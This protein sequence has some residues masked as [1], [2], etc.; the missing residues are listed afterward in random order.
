[1]PPLTIVTHPVHADVVAVLRQRCDVDVCERPPSPEALAA[2]A[3]GA[4]ALLAFMPDRIDARLLD[5]CPEPVIVAG[6]LKGADNVDVEACTARGVWV[7]VV[8]DLL[9]APRQSS[10][11]VS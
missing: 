1:M 6:A 7:T 3:V 4:S 9:S 10:P 8:P 5:A 2:R 11:S